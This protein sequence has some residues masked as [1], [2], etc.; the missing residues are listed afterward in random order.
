MMKRR[1]LWIP[2]IIIAALCVMLWKSLSLKPQ[3]LE[4]ALIGQPLPEFEATDL[5]H[6]SELLSRDHLLGQP[7]LLN[8]WATWCPAC[9]QEHG[10]LMRLFQEHEV[11][12]VGLNYREASREAAIAELKNFGNPYKYVLSDPEGRLGLDL[13]VYGA[14]ETFI[15]DRAGVIRYRYAGIINENIWHTRLKPVLDQLIEKE[16]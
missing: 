12:I 8:V 5:F 3:E 9:K 1:I 4:S 13:G 10:Y 2:F 11:V 14:P 15:V 7:F 16:F 6:P